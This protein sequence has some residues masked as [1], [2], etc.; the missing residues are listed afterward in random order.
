MSE[1]THI[2]NAI[3]QGDAHAAGRLLPLVYDEL[4]RLAARRLTHETP[5]QTLQATA[6]VHEAYVRL[7]GDDPNKRWDG[8]GHFFAAAAE[9]MRRILVEAARRKGRLKHGGALH[10][11]EL[12][13]CPA[14]TPDEALLALDEALTRL[15][16]EDPLAARVVELRHFAGLGH[17]ATAEA[18]GV[19]VYLARQK[20]AYARAWLGDAL[21]E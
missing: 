7:V 13:D 18:L 16:V 3:G 1:V 5:G 19:T 17:E 11:V 2:L 14:P 10:R 15:A 21:R 12:P 9:A 20:W 6:L 4:R 8:R